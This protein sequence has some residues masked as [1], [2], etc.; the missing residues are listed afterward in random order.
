MGDRLEE[1]TIPQQETGLYK[2]S[3]LC[4]GQTSWKVPYN[5]VT[6]LTVLMT[7][8]MTHTVPSRLRIKVCH[9]HI[10]ILHGIW[11]TAVYLSTDA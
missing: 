8:S 2:N 9:I 3:Q 7:Q 4:V 5:T 1:V 6:G 10:H 11:M